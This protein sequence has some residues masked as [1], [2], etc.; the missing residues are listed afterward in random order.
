MLGG[1]SG[2]SVRECVGDVCPSLARQPVTR[3]LAGSSIRA[4]PDLD[5]GRVRYVPSEYLR[6]VVARSLY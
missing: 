2:V 3:P 5:P 6:R 4:S 1:T